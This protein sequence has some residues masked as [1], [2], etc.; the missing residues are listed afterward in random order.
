MHICDQGCTFLARLV[1]TGPSR[2]RVFNLDVQGGKPPYFARDASFIDWYER[3]LDQA[4][5]GEPAGWSGYDNPEYR[6]A[7]W[8]RENP[9]DREPA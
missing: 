5:A 4:E 1:V 6:K 7:G 9:R 3:W 8:T 2:G